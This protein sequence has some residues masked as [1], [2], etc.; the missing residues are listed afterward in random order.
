ME[1]L[2]SL[3]LL[4]AVVAVIGALRTANDWRGRAQL[5]GCEASWRVHKGGVVQLVV[6]ARTRAGIEFEVRPEGV[7]D[8]VAK[9][10]GATTELE[11]GHRDF[12]RRMFVVS[13][14]PYVHEG[15]RFD[16]ELPGAFLDVFDTHYGAQVHEVTEVACGG[17]TVRATLLAGRMYE[18]DVPSV[19]ARV[20]PG[21]LALA[22]RLDAADA[23]A[24]PDPVRRRALWLAA[25]ADGLAIHA[26]ALWLWFRTAHGGFE[27]PRYPVHALPFPAA[28]AV[29]LVLAT[30]LVLVTVQR[31]RGTSRLHRTL[32]EVVL[33]G[34]PGT[35][36]SALG[37]MAM[38][39]L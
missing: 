18:R 11:L 37:W 29:A 19:V 5:H 23:R 15:L 17:H 3:A 10:F 4:A 21:L 14:D 36:V 26:I 9:S 28:L 12:D 39:P 20:A 2:L 16:P 13:D 6:G 24:P 35:V 22:R 31:L 38:L 8:E 25:L 34:V 1:F 33:L 32:L 7:I 30:V 27:S